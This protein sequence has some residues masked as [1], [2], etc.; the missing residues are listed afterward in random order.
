MARCSWRLR[1]TDV[2][3]GLGF[4]GWGYAWLEQILGDGW[5]TREMIGNT[6]RLAGNCGL[7]AVIVVPVRRSGSVRPRC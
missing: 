7:C 3:L 5:G 2:A 4:D 6:L 1:L